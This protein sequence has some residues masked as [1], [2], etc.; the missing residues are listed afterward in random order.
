MEIGIL[1]LKLR[2]ER[3]LSQSEVAERLGICQS[4]YCA[5]ESDR[6]TPS[7]K[8]YAPLAALLEI[9][10]QD[11]MNVNS[12]LEPLTDASPS[13]PATTLTSTLHEEL[14]KTQRETIV[15]QKQRI[16]HLE[17]ESQQLKMRLTEVE[18]LVGDVP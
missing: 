1:L 16:E 2:K 3:R 7:A 4:A 17:T 6:V 12:A 14:V 18:K 11:L 5:W 13:K 10:I 9:D 8:Y 15:L